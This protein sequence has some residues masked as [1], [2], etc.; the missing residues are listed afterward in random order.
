M[1]GLIYDEKWLTRPADIMYINFMHYDLYS[2]PQLP[3]LL[4]FFLKSFGEFNE[5]FKYFLG[6]ACFLMFQ[7]VG[8][9]AHD[10]PPQPN[11]CTV[12]TNN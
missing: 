6:P 12:C 5:S 8:M 1:T 10:F 11:T 3:F 2:S 4:Q 7:Q 9:S